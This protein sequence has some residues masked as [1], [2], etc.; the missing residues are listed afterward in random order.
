MATMGVKR[1]MASQFYLTAVLCTV[2][3]REVCWVCATLFRGHYHWSD[4]LE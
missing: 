3:N 1:L 2:V 4:T